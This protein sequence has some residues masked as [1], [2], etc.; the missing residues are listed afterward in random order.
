LRG[1]IVWNSHAFNLTQSETTM[2]Q[3]L[4]LEFAQPAD[5]V[6]PLQGIFDARWIFAQDVPAFG[7]QEICATHTI[8]QGA[9]LFELGSHT[10]VRGVR[11]R[12]WAPPNTP[13]QPGCPK[14]YQANPIFKLCQP[15][16]DL[17]ICDGPPPPPRA[18]LYFS[19]DYS[20]PLQLGFDPPLAYDDPDVASRTFLFCSTYDNGS[21]PG[22]PPVKLRSKA[23]YPPDTAGFPG[24]ILNAVG[25]GG[26]CPKKVTSCVD[27][28]NKGLI[29]GTNTT[30]NHAFC[31]DP[32]LALCDACPTRGGVTTSDEMYILL[33]S[34]FVPVPEPDAAWLGGAAI[35][36][37]ALR[38]SRRRRH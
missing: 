27:G 34:Y 7:T 16:P 30:L 22:S 17:P 15:D 11:W 1:V 8:E 26:P 6:Y 33:G 2:A 28:P 37:L 38:N 21:G 36:A 23:P 20:D 14:P 4:N 25:I 29:C 32:A 9:R 5:Q 3:F 19:S 35:A 10:H 18:P 13:C 24:T 12:T 31:G